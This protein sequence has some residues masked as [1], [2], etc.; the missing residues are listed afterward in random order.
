MSFDWEILALITE[1]KYEA[2]RKEKGGQ[3]P[4]GSGHYCLSDEPSQDIH[5]AGSSRDRRREAGVA[6]GYAKHL[7]SAVS[8]GPICAAG[9]GTISSKQQL[10]SSL[11]T[12]Q[13]ESSTK[14]R[15]GCLTATVGP[16]YLNAF[17]NAFHYKWN[18]IWKNL[19][20]T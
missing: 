16:P 8:V 1:K 5:I 12:T 15:L 10:K 14:N 7:W 17:R 19:K 6:F 9:S 18:S 2:V 11:G 20:G 13:K 3:C 4:F